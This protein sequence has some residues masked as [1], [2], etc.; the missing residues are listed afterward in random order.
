MCVRPFIEIDQ[1]LVVFDCPQVQQ[2]VPTNSRNRP[3]WHPPVRVD[4]IRLGSVTTDRKNGLTGEQLA[5]V[6]DSR[7]VSTGRSRMFSVLTKGC[8]VGYSREFVGTV[9]CTY[10]QSNTTFDSCW[11]MIWL[12]ELPWWL[13]PTS[14][15]DIAIGFLWW[16]NR[17][18]SF[19]GKCINRKDNNNCFAYW[20]LIDRIG[21]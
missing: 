11:P 14:L 16:L 13:R 10:G 12:T 15:L 20:I 18:A 7:S 3:T 4:F 6:T 17:I 1:N 5:V 9:Y 21:A 19:L 2:A 8:H